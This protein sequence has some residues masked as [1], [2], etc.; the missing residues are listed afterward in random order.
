MLNFFCNLVFY[1]TGKK[2]YISLHTSQVWES[3]KGNLANRFKIIMTICPRWC[4]QIMS[5]NTIVHNTPNPI[6]TIIM[7]NE[8]TNPMKGL[9]I[10]TNHHYNQV[11]WHWCAK[12]F[13]EVVVFIGASSLLLPKVSMEKWCSGLFALQH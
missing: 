4:Y 7:R 9:K 6:Y 8:K 2:L 10:D 3:H 11:D 12:F 5:K 13:V 1:I